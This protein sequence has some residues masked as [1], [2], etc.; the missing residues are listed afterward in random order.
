MNS[1]K[2]QEDSI[3][4]LQKH[5][6]TGEEQLSIKKTELKSLQGSEIENSDFEIKSAVK[7]EPKA[8]AEASKQQAVSEFKAASLEVS[9][10]ASNLSAKALASGIDIKSLQEKNNKLWEQ[11]YND[12]LKQYEKEMKETEQKYQK[13]LQDKSLLFEQE[14]SQLTEKHK[15][16][17]GATMNK[18]TELK[19][20]H[21]K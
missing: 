18:Y 6:Q 12:T 2:R 9:E 15:A 10:K 3:N 5:I 11:K 20:E 21:D 13:E 4:E 14:S 19:E 1:V 7:K 16:Q 17:L 8:I